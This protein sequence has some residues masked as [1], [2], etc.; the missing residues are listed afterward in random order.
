[1]EAIVATPTANWS[2]L[3]AAGSNDV[4]G[5]SDAP[6]LPQR[7]QCGGGEHR[8]G[9]DAARTSEVHSVTW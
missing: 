5:G 1:L 9:E 7:H 8:A 2:L 3:V 6:P 4:T